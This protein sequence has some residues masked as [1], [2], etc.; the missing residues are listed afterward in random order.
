MELGGKSA[1]KES[2][3]DKPDKL[4]VWL[5]DEHAA[6]HSSLKCMC[7]WG[8]RIEKFKS[9]LKFLNHSSQSETDNYAS[10]MERLQ[11]HCCYCM[12]K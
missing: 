8:N 3:A 5:F 1:F 4:T 7:S 9:K 11:K 2:Y 12:F 6:T 10:H